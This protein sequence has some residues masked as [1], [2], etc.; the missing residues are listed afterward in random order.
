MRDLI[1]SLGTPRIYTDILHYIHEGKT[2]ISCILVSGDLGSWAVQ[3]S[4][5]YAP[6]QYIYPSLESLRK[7]MAGFEF[8]FLSDE[9]ILCST[10][11]VA[12]EHIVILKKIATVQ[13]LFLSNEQQNTMISKL[14]YNLT[15]VETILNTILEPVESHEMLSTLSDAMGE[16]LLSFTILYENNGGSF[17]PI[18]TH[19][20]DGEVKALKTTVNNSTPL[21]FSFPVDLQKT[22]IF[23]DWGEFDRESKRLEEFQA[24]FAIPIL[25]E[26]QVRFVIITGRKDRYSD[27]DLSLVEGLSRILSKV[28]DYYLFKKRMEE[29]EETITKSNFQL[30][31]F[32]KSL[33]YLFAQDSLTERV[34]F[35]QEMVRELFHADT[36]ILF[37]KKSWSNILWPIQENSVALSCP[38]D[39]QG[40]ASPDF[41][42]LHL[43]VVS[44]WDVYDLKKKNER[45]AFFDDF[46]NSAALLELLEISGIS[47]NI[48]TVL[49]SLEGDVLAVLLLTD[50][51]WK[52]IEFLKMIATLAGLSIHNYFIQNEI[53]SL[54]N[55][56]ENVMKTFHDAQELYQ[57]IRNT[58]GIA[59]FY[60]TL[61][62]KLIEKFEV[63]EFYI[64]FEVTHKVILLPEKISATVEGKLMQFFKTH[65]ESLI[66]EYFP[67]KKTLLYV[68]STC[69]KRKKLLF[70]I[71]GKDQMKMNIL[72]Q[73]L[74]LGFKDLLADELFGSSS[75]YF[76]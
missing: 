12:E 45:M 14:T 68:V 69:Y 74:Q 56:Y 2:G 29:K 42:A 3:D 43:V 21:Y 13:R 75:K 5:G 40:R 23:P 7:E 1:L 48:A 28:M 32:Y 54:E 38:S 39:G 25:L 63:V 57:H 8:Y 26:E 20:Y 24:L 71:E 27:T 60:S 31:S 59:D 33:Q 47:P 6:K 52:D 76:N 18:K 66:I 35:I 72:I 17:L 64:V 4:L 22:P 30:L 58:L 19:G 49:R 11:P 44:C 61:R 73:L 62:E 70:A 53:K 10:L 50:F 37:Y 51:N 9:L 16:L 46:G 41:P 15:G 34:R 67:E 36:A 65:D 55:S